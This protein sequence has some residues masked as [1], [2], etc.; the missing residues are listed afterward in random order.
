MLIISWIVTFTIIVGFG[1]YAGS[2]IKSSNQWSGGDKTLGALGVG[3]IL[4]AWQI[5]GMSIVGAAQNGYNIGIAGAWYSL[6][7]CFYFLLVALLGN[8]IRA[9]MPSDSVPVYLESRFSSKSGKLYS[10]IWLALGFLYIPIQLLTISAVI[11]IVFPTMTGVTATVIGL[12]IAAIYTGFGGMKGAAVIGKIVCLGIYVVLA[13][14]GDKKINVIKGEDY[15][16]KD[17]SR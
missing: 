1:I 10:Y 17:F 13:S 16:G 8:K 15:A 7:G 2:K 5:G 9:N 4:A 6:A 3:S 11:R 12:A 14:F